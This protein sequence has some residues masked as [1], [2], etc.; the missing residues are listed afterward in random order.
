MRCESAAVVV[1][2]P[3]GVLR[4][5]ACI[6]VISLVGAQGSFGAAVL[7][8]SMVGGPVGYR[9]PAMETTLVVWHSLGVSGLHGGGR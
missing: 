3:S 8:A 5:L 4:S 1:A 2:S 6:G 7:G 9:G